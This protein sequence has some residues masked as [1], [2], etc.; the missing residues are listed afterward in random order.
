MIIQFVLASALSV[1]AMLTE[2]ELSA[3]VAAVA[4]IRL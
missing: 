3:I 4:P 2:C 1:P